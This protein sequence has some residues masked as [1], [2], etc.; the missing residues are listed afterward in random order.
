MIDPMAVLRVRGLV[1]EAPALDLGEL[2]A[3]AV[4]PA[5]IDDNAPVAVPS[6]IPPL[7]LPS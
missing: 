6:A 4:A 3:E 1:G 5:P 7:H 2:V